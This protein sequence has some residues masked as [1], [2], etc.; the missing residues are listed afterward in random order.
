[1]DQLN[2]IE[3]SALEALASITTEEALQAWK[4]AHLG[5]SS[6]LM[7]V[8]AGLGKLSK[9]EKPA[10][11]AAANRVKVALETALAARE[12]EIKAAAL[13]KSLEEDALDVTLPGR[14][15]HVGRLHPSTQQLRRVLD[16]LKEMGFQVYTSRE[17]ETDEMNFQ[18]LNF[19]LHH[20]A[21]DMQDSFYVESEGRGDNPILLRTHTSPGQIRAMREFAATNPQNPP[22]IRI[23]LPGM[24]FRYEQVTSRSEMQFNQVE[25]LAVGEGIT[26]ADL[27]GTLSDFARRMFGQNART[28]FRSDH[29]PF[30]E[31]SA[32][33]DVECFVCGGKGCPVCKRSG[34][35]EILGCG[36]VH[37]VVLQNGGY[38]PKRYSGFAWGMGP[39]RQLMLRYKID[40]IRYFWSNDIRFLGQF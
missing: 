19:P 28:R 4:T 36:M 14:T 20:P 40:D 5:R 27:K 10:V 29:F 3:S 11:G 31:P 33:M 32:E 13:A 38:D 24:C 25:G 23:A 9:E 26:F 37:P 12:T 21:R 35:L 16:I 22:P 1:M 15:F 39:E 6:R 8:F 18:L 7:Q 30:T 2:D 34:W 17:V